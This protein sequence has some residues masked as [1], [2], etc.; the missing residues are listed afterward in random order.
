VLLFYYAWGGRKDSE[1][2]LS[3]AGLTGLTA[4][5]QRAEQL[6]PVL[7][8]AIGGQHIAIYVL[9]RN[10]CDSVADLVTHRRHALG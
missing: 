5:E 7:L 4:L 3:L 2:R 10:L 1:S 9:P 6:R 8:G